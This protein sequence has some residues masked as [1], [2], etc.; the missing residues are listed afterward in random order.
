MLFFLVL[1]QDIKAQ[2]QKVSSGKQNDLIQG[3]RT[4]VDTTYERPDWQ[5]IDIDFLSSYY[6]Q[7]GNNSPVTGGIGTEQLTDFTQKVKLSVPITKKLSLLLD[8]GYDYY[9]SASTDNID[10]IRSSDSQ[11]DVRIHSNAAVSYQLNKTKN[12]SFR[13]GG[14]SEYDYISVNGGVNFD[15][16]TPDQNTTFSLGLQAFFDSWSLIYPVELRRSAS[17]PT[18]QRRS[19]NGSLGVSH[20]LNKKLQIALQAEAIYMEGLL[21]TPFHRVYFKEQDMAR[22]EQLPGTRLKIPI[23]LRVNGYISE[24]LIGRF[25]YRY[26]WD[27]WGI[28][29]HTIGAELPVKINRF[30]SVYPFYRY[31]TQSASDYFFAV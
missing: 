25:Y 8:G 21:S 15:M 5:E 13:I 9:S 24:H 16:Q 3:E 18:D 30:F 4:E 22:I 27:D 7:D 29:A 26:Y 28:Q 20:I 23:G 19:Y 10:N 17:L 11:S 14:S 6:A 1:T 12:I 31:H 2:L